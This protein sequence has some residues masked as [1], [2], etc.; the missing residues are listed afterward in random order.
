MVC[1][2]AFIKQA[3]QMAAENIICCCRQK[4]WDALDYAQRVIEGTVKRCIEAAVQKE[5]R[6]M[7]LEQL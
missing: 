2:E 7:D 6:M 4:G 5:Q 1:D 3:S